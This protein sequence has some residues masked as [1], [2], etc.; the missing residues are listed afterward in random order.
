MTAQ[1]TVDQVTPEDDAFVDVV[2]LFEQY[3]VHYGESADEERAQAW[4]QATMS[5]GDL[6]AFLA[7]T[8]D[9]TAVAVGLVAPCPASLTMREFWLVRDIYVVPGQRRQG[10]GRRLLEAVATAARERGV[11]RL[12]LQ[13]EEDNDGALALYHEFGFRPVTGL[14]QLVFGLSP[15]P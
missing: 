12:S 2:S 9:A 3:R 1:V 15:R 6:L 8:S 7:R 4:L 5:A 13:T 10:V 14:R 11:I